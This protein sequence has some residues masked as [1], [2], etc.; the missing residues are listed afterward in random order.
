MMK[1]VLVA[2]NISS[3][4]RHFLEEKNYVLIAK[5][6]ED[7]EGIVTSNKLLLDQT[8]IASFP[9]LKWIARLGSGMEIIDTEYCK[10]NHILCISSPNGIANAVA[11][12]AIG[13][14]LNLFHHIGRS[15]QEIHSGLWL[16]EENRG[17]ELENQVV[18]IIGYGHTGKAFVDKLQVFTKHI[19]VYDKYL[20]GFGTETVKEVE[21]EELM[22]QVDILS[23]HVPLNKETTHYYNDDFLSKMKKN[24]VLLNTSRGAVCSTQTILSGLKNGK[25]TGACL[26]VLE[27]EKNITYLLSQDGNTVEELLRFPTILTPHI[28]G[29]SVNAIEK[30]CAELQHQLETYLS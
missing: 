26:D 19:L 11:E 24:H 7:V 9:N 4:F 10:A 13:M 17:I 28:A 16:R 18:G 23:F 22:N 30:M 20:Q 2:A 3:T 5:H 14:L 21:L 8:K 29:Y 27:E 12:H 15:H 6:S 25:I 1:K